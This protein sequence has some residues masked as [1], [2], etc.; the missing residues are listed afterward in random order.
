MENSGWIYFR[1]VPG[2][3][4]CF[5]KTDNPTRRDSEYRKENP[6]VEKIYDFFV[7]DMHAVE[8]ELVERTKEFRLLENSKEW[9]RLCDEAREIVDGV[10]EQYALMTYAEWDR[11]R[12]EKQ[13][14]CPSCHK[15]MSYDGPGYR[16]GECGIQTLFDP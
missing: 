4:Y 3:G 13:R 11:I 10:R 9:I 7:E 15:P 14:R 6:W 2:Q 12:A 5:G 1:I 16:C 8:A